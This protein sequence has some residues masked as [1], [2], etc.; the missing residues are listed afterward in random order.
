MGV[1]GPRLALDDE[2][3]VMA[4]LATVY[5]QPADVRLLAKLRRAG[6]LWKNRTGRRVAGATAASGRAA[7]ALIPQ[8]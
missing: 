8:G 7:R 3:R 6:E 5:E 2:A 1:G 4:L